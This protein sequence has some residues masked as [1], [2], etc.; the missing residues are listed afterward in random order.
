MAN[1]VQKYLS[2]WAEPSVELAPRLPGR[3]RYGV[4]I[5]SYREGGRVCEAVQS[6]L[7]ADDSV[8]V[9]V[10][11]NAPPDAADDELASN[12]ESVAGLLKRFG[13]AGSIGPDAHLCTV[14]G[15]AVVVLERR[16]PRKQGVGTA[17]KT[18][19]DLLFAA[20]MAGVVE[21]RVLHTTDADA[22]V[23]TTYL[24]AAHDAAKRVPDG[25]AWIHRFVHIAADP[26]LTA[27]S[28]R[29]ECRLRHHVLGLRWAGSPYAHQAIGSTIAVD[30][31]RYAQVRGVPKRS[32]GEDF[33]L[34]GK[35]AKLG[36]IVAIDGDPIV[37]EGRASTRV[38]F[39]TGPALHRAQQRDEP[40][41]CYHPGVFDG[42]RQALAAMQRAVEE[43]KPLLFDD[44]TSTERVRKAATDLGLGAMVDEINAL[45][46][47]AQRRLRR[48]HERFDAFATLKMLHTLRAM[49]LPDEPVAEALAAS[50]LLGELRGG[51]ADWPAQLEGLE[52]AGW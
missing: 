48:L 31:T 16:I 42:L 41:R 18:G 27:D 3:F 37:L 39:G 23:P 52:R 50:P 22:R 32:A 35:L 47:P 36:P 28:A 38:P 19:L 44:G 13:P 8:L 40:V 5:P 33:Y 2:R 11:V 30:A 25:A 46:W 21:S 43:N 17:R 34:L 24:S 51:L 26:D 20:H 45:D 49:G 15:S 10:V 7:A 4:C 29:Y 12:A 9:V 1:A 14:A 6:V